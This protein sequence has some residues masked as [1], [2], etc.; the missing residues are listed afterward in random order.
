M[1]SRVLAVSY[2]DRAH[3]RAA[4]TL[5]ELLVVIGILAVLASIIIAAVNHSRRAATTIKIKS[6]L[7]AVATALEAYK[8]DFKKYPMRKQASAPWILA[9][10]LVGPGDDDGQTGLGFRTVA[11]GKIWPSYL[12]TD[13]LRVKNTGSGWELLDSSGNAIQYYPKRAVLCK[14]GKTPVTALV[15]DYFGQLEYMYERTDGNIPA[16]VSIPDGCLR[17][18]LGDLSQNNRIDGT[19]QLRFAG[20]YILAS[21][22]PDGQWQRKGT[23]P[24]SGDD[25]YNFD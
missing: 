7:H 25:A 18:A 12:P 16:D 22:G 3:S 11:N 14:D 20:D 17:Y 1:T 10:A 15:G 4:F 9:Q 21:P 5:I 19:E 6:D 23:D 24:A 8:A 2:P 13:R